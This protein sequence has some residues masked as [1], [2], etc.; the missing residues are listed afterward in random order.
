MS[1]PLALSSFM[2]ST[3]FF[4]YGQAMSF[5]DQ[6]Q[7]GH[8]YYIAGTYAG[9][10]QTFIETPL[11]HIKIKLQNQR[12]QKFTGPIQCTRHLYQE[13]GV[14]SLF[15]GFNVTMLRNAPSYGVYFATY[16][17][18]KKK[19]QMM[20]DMSLAIS[21][22]LAGGLGGVLSWVVIYP[23]DVVKTKIQSDAIQRPQFKSIKD[24]FIKTYR[25][26]G[27]KGFTKGLQ[28][29]L[30]RTFIVSGVNFIGYEFTLKMLQSIQKG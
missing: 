11:E 22:F 2:S 30:A 23:I 17:V 18:F 21:M 12:T 24:C 16:E 6:P 5:Q 1:V 9:I 4:A 14:R 27:G 13:G 19:L 7:S 28:T 26:S 29:T 25:E 8:Q 15:K 3:L 10:V 20:T